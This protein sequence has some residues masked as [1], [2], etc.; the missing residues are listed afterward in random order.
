MWVGGI[1]GT[2]NFIAGGLPGFSEAL[3]AK[4]WAQHFLKKNPGVD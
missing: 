1:L 3:D 2:A 4:V